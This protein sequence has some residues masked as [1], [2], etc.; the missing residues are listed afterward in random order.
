MKSDSA[1]KSERINE[2]MSTLDKAVMN[3][4]RVPG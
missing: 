4:A 2:I 3:G 1:L